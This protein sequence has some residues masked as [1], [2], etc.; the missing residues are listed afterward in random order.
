MSSVA[1]TTMRGANGAQRALAAHWPEY[2]M[3]GAELGLFMLSACLFVALLEYPASPVRQAIEDPLVRRVLVG[4]TM[5][6]TAVAIVYSPIGKQ[7]GAHFNP[8]VTLTFLRLGKI[9]PWDALFYILAQFAGALG[10]VWLAIA[11]LGPAVVSDPSVNYVVTLPGEAGIGSAVA[12]EAIISFAL[13]LVVLIVSNTKNLNR[14]TGLFAGTLVAVYIAVEA[15][16]S[17][18]SMNP[19]R[20]LGSA[21]PAHNWTGLWIYFTAPPFG[22]LLAAEVYLRMKGRVLCCKLHHENNAHC[23]FRCKY[24]CDSGEIP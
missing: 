9:A 4:L 21:L 6:V 17:G 7:S 19:A 12:A 13:M 22:M 1:T 8:A 18:M 15:P 16:L 14:Y 23:I 24:G 5:G 11:L 2:L 10:G 3:E 20:T